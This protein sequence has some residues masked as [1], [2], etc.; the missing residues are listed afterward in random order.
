M[1]RATGTF[2]VRRTA[3]AQPPEDAA[4]PARHDLAKEFLG[5]FAGTGAGVMLSVGTAVAGSAA[6]CAL[7]TV[8]GRLQGREGSFALQHTGV[9]TRGAP[10]LSIRVVPDSGTGELVGIDGTF[11]IR[12]DAG[13]HHYDFDYSLPDAPA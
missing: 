2:T 13:V 10:S 9:M 3:H 4:L 1:A 8:H 5:D 11:A 6:Y 12:I 7:E